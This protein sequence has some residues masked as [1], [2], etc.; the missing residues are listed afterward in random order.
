[1]IDLHVH[2]LP[3]L[4]DGPRDMSDALEMCLQA[5]EDGTTTI[6][7]TPH[8]YNGVYDVRREDVLAGVEELRRCVSA[9]GIALTIVPGADIHIETDLCS[10]LRDG[11][12]VTVGDTGKYVMLE[13]PHDVMPQGLL[14]FLFSVQLA[15]VTPIISHPERNFEVQSDPDVLLPIVG[16][17][18]LL[19]VTA[20]SITGSFG[21]RPEA[22][23]HHLI[24]RRMA[25][26]VASDA[27]SPKRRRPLLSPARAVVGEMT[28]A[29]EAEELFVQRPRKIIA[30]EYVEVPDVVD[31]RR[32]RKRRGW[33]SWRR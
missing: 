29:E 33:F 9:A 2:I 32:A 10:H 18:N 19:Q 28:S 7:A 25:H 26:L 8:M 13:L 3:G 23:A 5:V 22:C 1:M 14:A 16:A 30:G 20:G 11:T 6:V 4:D 17:G 24:E 12:I 21:E 27:H 15:G 31:E